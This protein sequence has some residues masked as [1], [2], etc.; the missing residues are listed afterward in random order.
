MKSSKGST[1][2]WGVWSRACAIVVICLPSQLGGHL[3][4]L[5]SSVT[6]AV[7]PLSSF[8]DFALGCHSHNDLAE[9]PAIE[10]PDE[11]FGRF[12]QIV[13]DLLAITNTT[14]RKGCSN[15]AQELGVVLLG[16]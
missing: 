16:K 2:S 14:V 5:V 7:F 11:R 9:I 1:T 15:F 10:H 12:F 6:G 8:L 3:L 13:Y 4:L